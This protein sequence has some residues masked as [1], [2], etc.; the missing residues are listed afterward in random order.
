MA[1][2]IGPRGPVH[3][4][5]LRN[6]LRVLLAPEPGATTASVWVWYGIGSKNEVP[7]LTGVSHW[8]EHMLFNGS[9]RFPKGAMDRAIMEVGGYLNAFTDV[10]MT[11]YV[12]T[13]P[14]EHVRIPLEI[15]ADRMTRAR[16]T[17]KEVERERTIVLSERDG[18]ENWPEFRVEEELYEL[19]FRRHPYRWDPL[20]FREDIL[21]VDAAALAAYY[22]TYYGTRNALLV[23]AGRFEEA[24]MRRS[25]DRL[26]GRLPAGGERPRARAVEPT[27]TGE[28]RSTLTGVGTTPFFTV[29]YR[30]VA[31]AD[32][33][34]PA[35]I[36]LDTLLGGETRMFSAS[37]WG[38]SGDHPSSR[39]YRGLVDTG[40]AIRASSE[41]RPRQDPGLFSVHVQAARGVTLDRI[42]AAL[43]AELER[44]R[45][46]GPTRQELVEIREKIAE[47]ARLAY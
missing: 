14:A 21:G 13:V 46:T 30:S 15:E 29:G 7:G 10:D 39:L 17:E 45:R 27:P 19:A 35:T 4:L 8:V 20:G 24:D 33:A 44:L 9:P 25:I 36:I 38:R 43:D 12:S 6:G 23:V 28:R 34:A 2:A 18:N 41:W 1:K 32:P 5:R 22:R 3:R 16:M 31:A 42:E 47:S 37:I 26:F 11:A 40:L